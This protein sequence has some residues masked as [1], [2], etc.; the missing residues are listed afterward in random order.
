MKRVLTSIALGALLL[1]AA[2][3]AASAAAAAPSSGDEVTI[4]EIR[5]RMTDFGINEATQESLIAGILAGDMPDADGGA[6]PVSSSTRTENGETITRFEFADG[7]A[8]EA[9]VQ[10]PGASG[11][12]STQAIGSCTKSSSTTYGN[13]WQNCY[14]DYNAVTWSG[15][16]YQPAIMWG[17]GKGAGVTGKPFGIVQGGAGVSGAKATVLQAG[18]K[19]ASSMAWV[20]WQANQSISIGGVGV[21][22]T[23]GFD[24]KV[25]PTGGPS[26]TS[27]G[28]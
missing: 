13:Y 22:R 2:P 3:V 27:F 12:I 24:M 8:S 23:V 15:S 11:G 6:A 17:S 5:E 19:T 10:I 25:T 18:G 20:R 16:Y 7:S 9:V 28:G 26:L 14:V 4:A 1:A 21:N